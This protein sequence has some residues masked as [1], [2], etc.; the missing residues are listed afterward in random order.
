M[1]SNGSQPPDDGRDKD[2]QALAELG[3]RL[4]DYAQEQAI[5]L[6]SDDALTG[7]FSRIVPPGEIPGPVY[8]AVAALL[9]FLRDSEE[10]ADQ[11]DSSDA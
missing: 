10:A 1:S 6:E 3:R 4:A 11:A 7:R 2:Q 5:D 8:N 9:G